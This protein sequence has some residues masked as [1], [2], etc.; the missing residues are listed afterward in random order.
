M[1]FQITQNQRYCSFGD[2][3][4]YMFVPYENN[5]WPKS[6]AECSFRSLDGFH[7]ELVKCYIVPCQKPHRRD[8][9][10]GFWHL[11]QDVDYQQFI[12]ML[13]NGG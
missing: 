4:V 12:K 9:M 6:C 11:S 2:G 10:D 13:K 8:N 1:N 3:L 7:N 5:L